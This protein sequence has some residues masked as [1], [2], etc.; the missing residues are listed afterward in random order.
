MTGYPVDNDLASVTIISEK[1]IDADAL[2]TSLF[3][4]GVEKG[5]ELIEQIEDSE[6]V[7]VTKDKKVI[8]SPGAGD[9][10]IL[11]DEEYEE[12]SLDKYLNP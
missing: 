11:L 7:F 9:L 3:V 6:A 5:M 8:Y 1:S 2:S 10:F 4:L 12:I